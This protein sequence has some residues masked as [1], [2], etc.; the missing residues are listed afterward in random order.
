MYRKANIWSE[1]PTGTP[2]QIPWFPLASTIPN[3]YEVG[4]IKSQYDITPVTVATD[5][6][7]C[8]EIEI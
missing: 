6:Y 5:W 1:A 3:M 7:H 8:S 4:S 2:S